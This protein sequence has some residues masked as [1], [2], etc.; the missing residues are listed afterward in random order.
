MI[1]FFRQLRQKLITENRLSRYLLYAIG[2]IV[3]VVIGILIALQVNNWNE[4][5]KSKISEI[6]IL[7]R[8]RQ[9]LVTDT[10]YLKER[11]QRTILQKAEQYE[12]V[13][14][15]YNTQKSEKEFRKVLKL[16]NWDSDNLVLQTSTYE[17]LKSSG[18]INLVEN[19]GLKIQM[20][21]LYREYEVATKHFE[22]IN[23]L[24]SREFLPGALRAASKYYFENLYDE[25]RLF[26][27]T[28]WKFINDPTSESFKILEDTQLVYYMKYNYFITYFENLL[29]KSK[30][31]ISAIDM[32][33]PE[34]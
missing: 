6:K 2:E 28:D 11:L 29:I 27:G 10:L 16:Q 15:I 3:L 31:L 9:D 13:H 20:I 30:T 24:T 33:L 4:N 14:E 26:E 23:A 19:E 5:R 18:Q 7:N 21:N 17:E 22:E 8:L 32:E 1:R 25:E 12:F 34:R